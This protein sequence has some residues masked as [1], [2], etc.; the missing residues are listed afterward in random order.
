MAVGCM[1]AEGAYYALTAWSMLYYMAWLA[2]WQQGAYCQL[3]CLGMIIIWPSAGTLMGCILSAHAWSH[4]YYW[5][6]LAA[7]AG[8]YMSLT[9]GAPIYYMASAGMLAAGVIYVG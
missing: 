1:L 9:L 8:A 5:P 6:W 3:T 7:G 2:C 4:I